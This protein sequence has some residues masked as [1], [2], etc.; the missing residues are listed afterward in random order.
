MSGRLTKAFII[1]PTKQSLSVRKRTDFSFKER[2]CSPK[3][4]DSDIEA[5][6]LTEEGA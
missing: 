1:L 6:L 5:Q 2:L 4:T 3:D